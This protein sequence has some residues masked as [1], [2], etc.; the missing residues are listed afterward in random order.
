MYRYR[1]YRYMYHV[2]AYIAQGERDDGD[3][4]RDKGDAN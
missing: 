4:N 3:K 2:H 1:C